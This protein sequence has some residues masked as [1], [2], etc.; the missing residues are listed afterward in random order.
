MFQILYIILGL[1]GLVAGGVVIAQGDKEHQDLGVILLVVSIIIL[2][3]LVFFLASTIVL[4][5][6][7][8]K[9]TS[10]Y[11]VVNTNPQMWYCVQ[12]LDVVA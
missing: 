8:H 9:V 2:I 3:L 6:G 1:L 12:S 5:V 11:L 10:P 7:V 4:L